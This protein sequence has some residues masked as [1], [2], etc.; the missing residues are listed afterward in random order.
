MS[1]QLLGAYVLGVL[2]RQQQEVLRVHL[3]DCAACRREVDDLREME[4]ALG[5]IPPEAF[6]D[7]PPPDGELLLQKTLRQVRDE[8]RDRARQRRTIRIAVGVAAG[9]LALA[10]G[11]I[12][13]R[14]TTPDVQLTSAQGISASTPPGT[15]TGAATDPATGATMSVSVRPAAG[16]VRVHAEV[17]AVPA[18]EECRLVVVAPDGT[19]EPAGSWLTSADTAVVDGAALMDPASVASVQ[20]ETYAGQILVSVPV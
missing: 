3:D 9:L 11:L 1:S 18:G 5:E 12:A 19:R 4:A 20:A 8:N 13:G 2:D 6:L 15:R 16:W 7:G 14:L 10:G 17:G